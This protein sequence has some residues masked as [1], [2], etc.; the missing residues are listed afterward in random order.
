MLEKLVGSKGF[1]VTK[2]SRE[3][4]QD[5]DNNISVTRPKSIIKDGIN[6]IWSKKD[7]SS[8]W[9]ENQGLKQMCFEVI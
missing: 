5:R 3:L 1:S 8:L 4:V 2:K 6:K 7:Q 9:S